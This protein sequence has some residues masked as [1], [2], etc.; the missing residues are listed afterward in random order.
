[1]RK[2]MGS[3]MGGEIGALGSEDRRRN[4]VEIKSLRWTMTWAISLMRVGL[5]VLMFVLR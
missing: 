4:R 3:K 1:M 5:S 2:E